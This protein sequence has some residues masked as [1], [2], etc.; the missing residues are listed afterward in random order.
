[1]PTSTIIIDRHLMEENFGNAVKTQ[2]ETML[3][4]LK[5]FKKTLVA[6]GF[7]N[8]SLSPI[9]DYAEALTRL[10]EM[11]IRIEGTLRENAT[12]IVENFMQVDE[13]ISREIS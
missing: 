5:A 6:Q 1:M 3:E 7:L 9:V 2:T 11:L 10:L 12:G 4:T 13:G 8:S